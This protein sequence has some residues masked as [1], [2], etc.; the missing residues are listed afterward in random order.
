MASSAIFYSFPCN[1]T[2]ELFLETWKLGIARLFRT[3]STSKPLANPVAHNA[4][5]GRTS[6]WFGRRS[7]S[8]RKRGTTDCHCFMNKC[9]AKF[10]NNF[11]ISIVYFPCAPFKEAPRH[12]TASSKMINVTDRVIDRPSHQMHVLQ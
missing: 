6:V 1:Y 8:H 10:I 7:I 5:G 3:S 9:G 12:S 11:H 2:S 4:A